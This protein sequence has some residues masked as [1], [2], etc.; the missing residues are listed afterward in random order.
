MQ[1]AHSGEVGRVI[2]ELFSDIAP[3]TCENFLALCKGH[4]STP[5]SEEIGYEGSEVHRIVPGM[6]L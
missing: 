2:F 3:K 5:E 4:K 6:F 1:F